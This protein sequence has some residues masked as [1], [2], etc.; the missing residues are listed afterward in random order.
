MERVPVEL[1]VEGMSM[2]LNTWHDL[3]AFRDTAV[4]ASIEASVKDTLGKGKKFWIYDTN[5]NGDIWIQCDRLIEVEQ[6]FHPE[7]TDAI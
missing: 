1:E 7:P 6:L 3:Q 2:T 5:N 4:F